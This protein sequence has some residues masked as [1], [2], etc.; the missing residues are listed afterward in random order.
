VLV[1]DG[2]EISR[3]QVCALLR[4]RG[5]RPGEADRAET[6]LAMMQAALQEGDPYRV[7]L[8]DCEMPEMTGEQL[9]RGILADPA[10]R[11]TALILM[12]PAGLRHKQLC[13]DP[14]FAGCMAK[15]IRREQISA[16]MTRALGGEKGCTVGRT[17]CP[18]S[19]EAVER[20]RGRILIAE[21]NIFN[22]QV[23]SAILRKLGY[24]ADAV[25]NGEEALE[26]LRRA[27]Y[28][29]VLMDCQM[30]V[31]NGYEA[32]ERIRDP[33]S[34]VRNP[35]VP[36]IALTAHAMQGDRDRCLAAGMNDYVA[37]PV[38]PATLDLLLGE[39][40]RQESPAPTTE[41][42][43]AL[44]FDEESLVERLMGDREL[45]RTLSRGFLQ[46]TP[47]Q[48]AAL[49][50]HI[51]A[52]DAAGAE[53]LAHDLK[54]AAASVSFAALKQA[55]AE[56]EMAIQSR[57]P[58]AMSARLTALDRQFQAA[59]KVMKKMKGGTMS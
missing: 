29:L 5:C 1:A 15:P 50:S 16:W 22:Q 8:L 52:G 13:K 48:L 19:L 37:K 2:R 14:G 59:E 33:Q 21:D 17:D 55:A 42:G 20:R 18:C 47:R 23:A 35:R 51:G 38:N 57:D 53:R 3:R 4:A 28:D 41:P 44:V 10:L 24:R 49:A 11:D 30:P 58:A 46:D 12:K 9:G 39:W 56:M 34:G 7:A 32:A 6:A 25:A 54:G 45:A 26:S 27:P 36:I 40:L 43:G 31:M